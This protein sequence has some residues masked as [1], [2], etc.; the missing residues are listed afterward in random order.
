MWVEGMPLN[1]IGLCD[2]LENKIIS[3]LDTLIAGITYNG[4][5]RTTADCTINNDWGC[6]NYNGQNSVCMAMSYLSVGSNVNSF[7]FPPVAEVYEKDPY[8]SSDNLDDDDIKSCLENGN[9]WIENKC[10][11]RT[12]TAYSINKSIKID[13]RLCSNIMTYLAEPVMPK[14]IKVNVIPVNGSTLSQGIFP[15]SNSPV[16]L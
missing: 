4:I 6:C 3:S 8:I 14:V 9:Y 12:S 7:T 1:Y 11:T 13:S 5:E 15:Y 16:Q 10:V 2:N